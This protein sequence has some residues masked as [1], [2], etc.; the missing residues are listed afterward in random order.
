MSRFQLI[1]LTTA[2]MLAWF[3]TA[4]P[5]RAQGPAAASPPGGLAELRRTVSGLALEL[6]EAEAE[7]DELKAEER[8]LSAPAEGD[9]LNE[10]RLLLAPEEL[11][12]DIF[13]E[14][15]PVDGP[16]GRA[17]AV[18]A[19]LAKNQQTIEADHKIAV[20][21]WSWA[22]EQS[23]DLR[24]ER[25]RVESAIGWSMDAKVHR[26]ALPGSLLPFGAVAV[27]ASLALLF[28]ELRDR[29]RWRLRAVG[30]RPSTVAALIVAV[31]LPLALGFGP[32]PGIGDDTASSP[33]QAAASDAPVSVAT[34]LIERRDHVRQ[35]LE[36]QNQSNTAARER[37]ATRLADVR[38][39]KAAH[40]LKGKTEVQ[41]SIVAHAAE[42]ERKVQEGFRD[43][44]IKAR[45]TDRVLKDADR[46]DADRKSD[47]NK[48]QVFISS[49]RKEATRNSM[50]RLGTCGAFLLSAIVPLALVRR[51][52]RH[53]QTEQSRKC[54]RCLNKDT[55]DFAASET[56]ADNDQQ[57]MFRLKYCNYCKYEVRENYLYQNRLCFPT[58]GIRGS[59]K[60]HWLLMLYDQIKNSNVPVASA[61][62]KIPSREDVRFDELVQRLLY[63]GGR[64]DPT[65][66]GSLPHPITF[67]VKDADPLGSNKS[68]VNVFDFS[69][70]MR[71][72]DVDTDEFRRRALL[73]EGFTLF[74]DPT[75]VSEG[76]SSMIESQIECLTKFAEEMHAIRGLSAESP[77]DL[78]IA[79]CISKMD[80]LV[81]DNPMRTLAVPLVTSLRESMTKQV[82]LALIHQRSQLVARVMTQMFPNWNV[83]RSLR[84][85]FG[86]RYMFFPMSAVGLEEAELG[87]RDIS[88]RTIAPCG[89]IEP[90]LW[91]LHMHGYC[92][93]H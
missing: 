77:I 90:L 1:G 73:C 67:H 16:R 24:E 57:T 63:A 75:Q 76:A 8:L 92:V 20:E 15:K 38:R 33:A 42:V 14:S 65:T 40:G 85:N 27:L 48:L 86:G 10:S 62:R 37:V 88:A 68:M 22:N 29:L 53:E 39:A 78:P 69:G 54:P 60:T 64:L 49:S 31:V 28:H 50:I 87:V 34:E 25:A 55:L 84:E 13:P 9:D 66:Y 71:N 36:A 23:F 21:E 2:V 59:G 61:I 4:I 26:G 46:I 72:F 89:M 47:A 82:N 3:A 35:Q 74:L 70:E 44:R 11:W 45:A 80:L 30:S 43:L 19:A 81:S 18:L 17:S 5:T 32:A 6:I 83:E 58:V 56:E 79:V 52:R 93:L 41:K 51:G 12:N 91:L 7:G